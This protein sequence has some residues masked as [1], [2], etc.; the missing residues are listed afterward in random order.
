[1]ESDF[2][3]SP[4][5]LNFGTGSTG[6]FGSRDNDK[7]LILNIGA[8]LNGRKTKSPKHMGFRTV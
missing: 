1:L 5:S 3:L 8:R 7:L 4:H 2:S 6:V